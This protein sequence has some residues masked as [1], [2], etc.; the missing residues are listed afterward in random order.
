M[1]ATLLAARAE[2]ERVIGASR[3]AVV[4]IAGKMAEKIVGRAVALDA[5]VM[6]EIAAEALGA[7]RPRVGAIRLRVH[8]A[9]LATLE[10]RRAR[11]V[12]A[13]PEGAALEIYPDESVDRL[14]CVVETSV[15]RVDGQLATQIAAL[16]RA[17]ANGERHG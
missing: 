12:A 9:D 7:C 14:G 17:L 10:P 5:A 3:G 11:L 15:G 6:A 8:P 2:A 13:L 4:A 16:E 1:A